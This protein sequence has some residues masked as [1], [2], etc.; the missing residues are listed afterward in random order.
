[1]G[2]DDYDRAFGCL[3]THASKGVLHEHAT[4][5]VWCQ[6]RMHARAAPES[7]TCT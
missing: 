1:M 6:R 2:D 3:R 7:Q 4:A 5:C